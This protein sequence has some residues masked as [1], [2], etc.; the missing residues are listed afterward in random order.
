MTRELAAVLVIAVLA[1]ALG[2][3]A[4]GWHRRRRSQAGLGQLAPVPAELGAERLRTELLYLATT[5][6]D[7]PVDRIAVAGLGFRAR[8]DLT[9]ADAGLVL[10]M[11]GQPARFIPRD[12][13]VGADRATWTIDRAVEPDGLALVRW[14]LGGTAVDSYFRPDDPAALV[15]AVRSIVPQS[16]ESEA[17]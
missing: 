15:R 13:L 5:R 4:L 1:A 2:L 9:V 14:R 12:D 7:A 10:A 11:T 6:A 8:T 16:P 17:A 3:M